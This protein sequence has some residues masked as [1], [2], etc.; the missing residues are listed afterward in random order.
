MEWKCVRGCPTHGRV[1]Y[2]PPDGRHPLTPPPVRDRYERECA[3]LET[4]VWLDRS[5]GLAG[6][7]SGVDE[8][9]WECAELA[10]PVLSFS[11]PAKGRGWIDLS[12]AES[13]DATGLAILRCTLYDD[14]HHHWA[15]TVATALAQALD[16]PLHVR[17]LGP[18]A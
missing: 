16:T 17:D 8:V 3:R 10:F 4:V 9:A 6:L 14:P 18:D 2:G 11:T 7:K 15:T 12:V 1:V 13:P 5:A